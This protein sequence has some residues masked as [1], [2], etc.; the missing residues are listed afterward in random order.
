MDSVWTL[1]EQNTWEGLLRVCLA[2]PGIGQGHT[3]KY[4]PMAENLQ[5]VSWDEF[6]NAESEVCFQHPESS[7]QLTDKGVMNSV[8][9]GLEKSV[10]FNSG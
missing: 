7:E 5:E 2:L 9:V 3:R 8:A 6:W 10:W 1:V 4:K